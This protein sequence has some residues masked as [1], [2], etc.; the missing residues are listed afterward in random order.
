MGGDF[1]D[2]VAGNPQEMASGPYVGALQRWSKPLSPDWFAYRESTP[3]AQALLARLAEGAPGAWLTTEAQDS[4]QRLRRRSFDL[5]PAIDDFAAS[6]AC[7]H[8]HGEHI[9]R[10]EHQ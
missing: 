6:R 3:E 8:D 10:R 2:F 1:S 4:L 5:L 7:R 9:R